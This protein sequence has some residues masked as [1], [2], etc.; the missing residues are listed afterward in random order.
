MSSSA[1]D[2]DIIRVYRCNIATLQ[3]VCRLCGY[4]DLCLYVCISVRE[5]LE[6]VLC[7]WQ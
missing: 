7:S 3:V 6:Y 4:V 5:L 1:I 2:Y